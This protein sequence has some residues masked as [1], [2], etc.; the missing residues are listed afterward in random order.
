WVKKEQEEKAAAAR[1]RRDTE[2]TSVVE[3]VSVKP[4]VTKPLEVQKSPEP[5]QPPDSAPATPASTPAAST[6]SEGFW[7]YRGLLD[8]VV[9]ASAHKSEPEPVT[10]ESAHTETV[11]LVSTAMAASTGMAV[12]TAISTVVSDMPSAPIDQSDATE[13]TAQ[14][15]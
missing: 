7:S 11:Q 15:E 12:P 5:Q 9:A 8:K 10:Q 13:V 6:K 2:P 3:P 4:L 1:G 14:P